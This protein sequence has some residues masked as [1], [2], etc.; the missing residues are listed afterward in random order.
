MT[1]KRVKKVIYILLVIVFLVSIIYIINYFIN[2]EKSKT[3]IEDI[4]KIMDNNSEIKEENNTPSEKTNYKIE[5]LKKIRE[6]NNEIIAWINIEG[7]EIN[8]P[9]L[10]TDNN[11]YYI[12]KNYKKQYDM[13]GSIFLDYRY[14]LEK[15]SDNF[16]V[17]GH[18]NNNGLMFDNL[19]EYEDES[20]YKMHP[21]IN[22]TTLEE[23]ETYKIIAVFK[24]KA[25]EKIENN[26][27]IYYN[28]VDFEKDEQYYDYIEKCK[29]RSLYKIENNINYREKL[30]TLSTCEYSRDNGRFVILAIKK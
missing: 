11:E 20:Y 3:E 15:P 12:T 6:Q 18:N 22:L 24:S 17:Y 1:S 28:Y 5:N 26:E 23:D 7:T 19:L 30:L 27:F 25:Y 4:R 16:L 9:I 8:Y 29:E 2:I 21:I 14:N 10:Q 13:N